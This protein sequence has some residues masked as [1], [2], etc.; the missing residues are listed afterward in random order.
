MMAKYGRLLPLDTSNED[1]NGIDG[2]MFKDLNLSQMQDLASKI[3]YLDWIKN[4]AA[5]AMSYNPAR[6]GQIVPSAAVTNTKQNIQQSTY[7]T[8]DLFT[9]HNEV[10]EKVLNRHVLNE[11]AAL[12]DSEYVASYV[13]DD[14]SRADL[15][16]DK[17]LFD[18]AEI[19]ITIRN[20]ADDFNTLNSI[21][22][23]G[24]AMIQ[25]QMI[26]FPEFIRL[27]L[28]NNMSDTLNIAERAEQK[29]LE[30]QEQAM[31][32]QQQQ[33]QMMMQQ[34]QQLEQMRQEMQRMQMEFEA[35]QKQLD[36]QVK[37]EVASIDTMKFKN[38]MDVDQNNQ[39]DLIQKEL[40]VLDSK[41]KESEKDR[42]M[43]K[44]I[45]EM[46][47]NNRIEVEKLKQKNKK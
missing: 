5:L 24:Q 18:L 11:R 28:S 36:R 30:K 23:L 6:L 10:I 20:N 27:Q 22:G 29:M 38:Q 8:Q 35:Q 37:L 42:E 31:Q 43:Q 21:K 34:Q 47:L 44:I 32:Q 2:Q 26:T 15:K 17:E 40:I 46:E 16:L 45:K 25:N 33:Q 1:I 41:E 19:G 12:K 3:Q 7:Q 13:L 14:M 9:I 4:Q 39:S